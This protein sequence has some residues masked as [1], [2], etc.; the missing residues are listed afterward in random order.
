LPFDIVVEKN[1]AL[2]RIQAKATR[3]LI[4]CQKAKNIYRFGTRRAKNSRTR[5]LE[6]AVDYFAFVALDIGKVAYIPISEMIART[7]KVKQTVEFKSREVTYAG[8]VYSNGT[9]RSPE[10]GKYIQDFTNL[11]L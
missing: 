5:V 11:N 6:A 4:S 7:G 3:G 9:V 1:G 2:V 10:W 8:R